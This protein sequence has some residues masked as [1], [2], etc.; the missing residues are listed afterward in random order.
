MLT[1][2]AHGPR[3]GFAWLMLS[4]A[5]VAADQATKAI[6]SS[7]LAFHERITVLP[8][9][10]WTLTHNTGIAFSMFNDGPGWTR[11]GLSAFALVVAAVFTAWL[12]RLPREDRWQA[13]ALA[14]IVGGAIGNVIDRLRFGHVVD[15]ILLYWRDWHWP[16]FNIAD[17]SIFVGAAILIL[18]SFRHQEKGPGA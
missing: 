9:F 6:A 17:S 8:F 14:L 5:I 11:Y 10:D 7:S 4:A 13:A 15:F 2:A 3:A 1:H 12:V 18:G 16:A